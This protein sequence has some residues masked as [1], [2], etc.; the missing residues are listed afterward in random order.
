MKKKNYYLDCYKFDCR[1]CGN[2]NLKRVV[3]LGYHP[4]ANNLLKKKEDKCEL[5]PLELNYCSNCHNCQLS[6]S[7][8]QKKMF[9]NYLYLSS[10]TKTFRKHFRGRYKKIH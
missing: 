3:S 6:V 5:Y 1:S 2:T 4:L 7:V 10:T 9:S 8:D